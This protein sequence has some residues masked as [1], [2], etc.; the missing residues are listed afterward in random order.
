[1][2]GTT[3]REGCDR[4]GLSPLTLELVTLAIRVVMK[5]M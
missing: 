2:G 1:M 4:G 3:H 5:Q